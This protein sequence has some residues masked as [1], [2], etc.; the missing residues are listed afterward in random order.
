M[1]EIHQDISRI[2]AT[3][4]ARVFAGIAYNV[5]NNNITYATQ[6]EYTSKKT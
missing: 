4:G 5:T 1:A 3:K 2:T 6:G